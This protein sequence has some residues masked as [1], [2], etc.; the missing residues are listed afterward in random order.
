MAR[1]ERALSA[2]MMMVTVGDA[3]SWK[4]SSETTLVSTMSLCSLK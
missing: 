1:V 2:L 4:A 3:S